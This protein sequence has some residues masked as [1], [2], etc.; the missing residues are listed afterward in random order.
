MLLAFHSL[1]TTHRHSEGALTVSLNA[2]PQ[3]IVM[4]QKE[5]NIKP[6]INQAY[7]TQVK[8]GGG[9]FIRSDTFDIVQ[10]LINYA[11]KFDLIL[12]YLN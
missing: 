6:D 11:Q 5:N 8:Q 3:P 12:K 2:Y 7:V 9:T 4:L 10:G 1:P